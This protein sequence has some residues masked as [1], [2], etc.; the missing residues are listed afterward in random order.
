MRIINAK[1]LDHCLIDYA[2]QVVAMGADS[3]FVVVCLRRREE[4][5]A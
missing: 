1:P 2:R 5:S 3:I 4:A